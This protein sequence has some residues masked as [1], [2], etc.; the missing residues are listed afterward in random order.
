MPDYDPWTLTSGGIEQD[1][2]FSYLD[3]PKPIKA[4][5]T[6]KVPPISLAA[7]KGP[8]PAVLKPKA[9][10]SYNPVFQDW[11][12]ILVE[13]GTKEVELER[14]RLKEAELHRENLNRI[15]IAQD[16]NEDAQAEDGSAWEGFES[17]CEGGEWLKKRRPERK[18]PAERNRIKR[19]K[20][21]ER[22]AKLEVEMKKR[23][24]QAHQ[25]RSIARKVEDDAKARNVMIIRDD[26]ASS[27]EIDDRIL[28]RRKFG[29][30]A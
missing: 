1:S 5:S 23:T 17:E 24:R 2:S 3:K 16:E 27:E 21:A 22:Q 28:R 12:K 14:K 7:G 25:I 26:D 15:A 18:T 13:E 8:F 30:Y 10:S 11:D 19:R 4:P 29:K 20:A 9:G 6:L